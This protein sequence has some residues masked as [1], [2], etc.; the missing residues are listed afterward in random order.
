CYRRT[1]SQHPESTRIH[2]S[3]VYCL[4]YHADSSPQA[5]R[6]ES[7]RWNAIHAEPLAKFIRP[8]ANDRS[9]ERRLRVGYLSPDLCGHVVASFFEPLITA[10]DRAG[11]EIFCYANV[12]SP[13]AM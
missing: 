6:E 2:E 1:V 5:I 4:H 12:D 13:D 9:P 3:L 8:H 11:Y 7:D 10:H